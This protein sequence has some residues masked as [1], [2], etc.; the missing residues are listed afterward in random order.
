MTQDR[1]HTTEHTLIAA[2]PPRA[3]YELVADVTRWP[4]VFGPSVHVEHLDRGPREER[5]ELWAMVGGGVT[6]WVSRRTLDPEVLRITFR[7]ERST[8]PIGAMGGEWVFRELPGGRTEVVLRHEFAAVDDDPAT[9]AWIH[10]ALDRNSAEELGV[11][12]RIAEFG[13]PVEDVVFSFTDTVELP[14]RAA[15]AYAFV[16]RADLWARRLPHVSRVR[17]DETVPGVQ[18]LEMDTVT[19]DGSAHTTRSVRICRDGRW[20]AY[21][22]HMTPKLLLGHSGLWT[23]TEADDGAGASVTARHT[24]VIDPAAVTGVLGEGATLA[25]ARSYVRDALGRNSRSTLAHATA[26]AAGDHPATTAT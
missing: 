2:A 18:E 4:A 26:Y 1:L 15:D 22:Q 21:K 12:G 10:R 8:P 20:I 7:Q 5:F 14:G 17:L 25:A 6:S 11:L 9:V 3:L 13:H 24:V 16:N 19:A 23:F